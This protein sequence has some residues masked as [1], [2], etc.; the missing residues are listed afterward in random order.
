MAL[1]SY[2]LTTLA[3]LKSAL[4]VTGS[5]L[6][7][8]LE[9]TINAV[10]KAMSRAA[11]R[12]FEFETDIEDRVKAY[13]TGR[14]VLPRAPVSTLTKIESIDFAGTVTGEIDSGSYGL[15][16]GSGQ[17]GVVFGLWG[18]TALG[19]GASGLARFQQAPFSL[20][21][22]TYDAGFVTPQQAEDDVLLTRDLPE[23]LEQACL[24]SCVRWYRERFADQT[25][26]SESY[27][28]HS[29]SQ[30]TGSAETGSFGVLTRE[31]L[32][33]A[34]SYRRTI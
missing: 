22:V 15:E 8:D 7:A 21:L 24:Q 11:D 12:V 34:R 28:D 33:I 23:D 25:I 1:A 32:A 29:I 3:S 16:D 4:G 30:A 6:D 27:P 5:T 9:F 10:S 18:S 26:S 13:G 31:S 20:L 17:S 19:G 14:I 2:A